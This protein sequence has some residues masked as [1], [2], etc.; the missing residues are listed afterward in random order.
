VPKRLSFGA[1]V[2]SWERRSRTKAPP[3]FRLAARIMFIPKASGLIGRCSTGKILKAVPEPTLAAALITHSEGDTQTRGSLRKKKIR[4]FSGPV[5]LL[6]QLRLLRRL[7][8]YGNSFPIYPD[9]QDFFS[10]GDKSLG[11]HC[12]KGGS[13]ASRR[14]RLREK[15]V[16]LKV[17]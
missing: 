3:I 2:V 4:Q 12:R 11:V 1:G 13:R 16:K 17:G 8:R 9:G 7:M 6:R 14:K 5:T 15:V 10:Q